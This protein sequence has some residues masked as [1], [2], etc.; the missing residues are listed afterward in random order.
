M[1]PQE[2][3]GAFVQRNRMDLARLRGYLENAGAVVMPGERKRRPRPK[4][5]EGVLVGMEI[6]DLVLIS[7]KNPV[8]ESGRFHMRRRQ[9]LGILLGEKATGFEFS[10]RKV[11]HDGPLMR[12]AQNVVSG[13][14]NVFV[15][16]PLFSEDDAGPDLPQQWTMFMV[17]SVGPQ[18][19][20]TGCH[21]IVA[22]VPRHGKRKRADLNRA[23]L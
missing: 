2:W 11:K 23:T 3:L 10:V 18:D 16:D 22:D 4:P 17:W 9:N 12:A 13:Q 19:T 5:V 20:V 14:R 7:A 21:A 1:D 6:R 8:F 15:Q